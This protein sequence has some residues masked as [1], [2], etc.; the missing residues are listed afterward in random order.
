M[1]KLL[2][3]TGVLVL[4]FCSQ[5]QV[6]DADKNTA[7][8]LVRQNSAAIGLTNADIENSIVAVTY[9]ITGT[10]VRMVYLQQ[11]FKGIPVFNQVQVLAF[12]NGK[13]VSQAGDRI[14]G[15]ETVATN[16]DGLPSVSAV[17]A[18]QTSLTSLKVVPLEPLVPITLAPDGHKFEFGKLGVNSENI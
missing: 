13:L 17:T 14:R 11:S 6:N 15:M 7:L 8:Q 16:K 10:D 1:K 12:R 18:L 5:A 3:L 4:A 2:L 9:I